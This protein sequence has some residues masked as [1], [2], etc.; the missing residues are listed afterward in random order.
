MR[1]DISD[2]ERSGERRRPPLHRQNEQSGHGVD[3][4]DGSPR[5]G[6]ECHP[7]GGDAEDVVR[8]TCRHLRQAKGHH[9]QRNDNDALR[10]CWCAGFFSWGVHE[11]RSSGRRS[12]ADPPLSRALDPIPQSPA[13]NIHERPG[14]RFFPLRD[15][16][17]RSPGVHE[18]ADVDAVSMSR[19]SLATTRSARLCCA[20]SR[21]ISISPS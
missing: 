18:I 5:V 2:K 16:F 15:L 11:R 14:D 12:V 21:A 10:R 4:T 19:R 6:G 13:K 20:H 9:Q 7:G 8:D 1:P 17:D 3:H